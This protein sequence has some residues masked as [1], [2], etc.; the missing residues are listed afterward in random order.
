MNSDSKNFILFIILSFLIILTW[1]LF[2]APKS[3][4]P[5][6]GQPTV[7]APGP[8]KQA[9][10]APQPATGHTAGEAAAAQ[11]PAVKPAATVSG[12]FAAGP[13]KRI[14]VQNG[15]FEIEF[16]SKGAVP[17]SWKLLQHKDRVYFPYEVNLRWPPITKIEP[18]DPEPVNMV[19]P[20]LAPGREPFRSEIHLGGLVV[21][22][23]A[24]WETETEKLE[25]LPGSGPQSLSFHL[26]TPDGSV[27][28]KSYTFR[29]DDYTAELEISLSPGPIPKPDQ[30][31]QVITRLSY[32]HDPG[33]RLTSGMSSVNF[34]GPLC[35]TGVKLYQAKADNLVKKGPEEHSPVTWAGFTESFF[36]T[37]LLTEPAGSITWEARYSGPEDL[38]QDKKAAK[39][40]TGELRVSPGE[41]GLKTGALL[42]V[43]LFVGPKQ[44]ELLAK[45]NDKLP[46]AIDY[47]VLY[48][49][50][51]PLMWCLNQLYQV[52]PNYG[53]CIVALTVILRM[54]MFPL[55]RK[56]QQSMKEMQKLQPEMQKLREKYPKDRMKQQEEMAAL[57][58]RYK[59]NPLGG[60]LPMLLQIPVFFAFY[61]ALLISVELRHAPFFGWIQDLSGRDPLL[62]WPVL[63]GAT[64]VAMQK[65]TPTTS[66][67]PT[68]AR[69]MMLMPLVFIFLLLYFPSGLIIYWTASNL[70]GIGQQIY[71]NRKG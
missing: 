60:C 2:M 65:M 12:E 41:E 62:V 31:V 23:Q 45:V 27:L 67:D 40:L 48:I 42:K 30:P 14:G 32:L 51:R 13:E 24:V 17:V 59:V 55:T 64:Q 39:E 16:S 6:P 18:F 33:S 69:M 38:R 68:Q 34:V 36:L 21:P 37:A 9:P 71:V 4:K 49:L 66:M 57:Y 3:K 47:G 7:Q 1:S 19:D 28:T 56:G 20:K 63:M 26:R 11:P 8:E 5:A 15:V 70:V 10:S 52:I 54:G 35:Y 58:K 50:V 29:P 46:L 25:L 22:E 43:R 44:R 53:V 61:K